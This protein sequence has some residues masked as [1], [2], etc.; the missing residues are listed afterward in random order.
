MDKSIRRLVLD[1]LKPSDK[2]TTIELAQLLCKID[3]VKGVNINLEEID[4]ET[5]TVKITIEGK[6]AY[7]KILELFGNYGVVVHSV[8]QVVAGSEVVE[9]VETPQD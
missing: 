6:L 8:D 1:V 7:D 3:D 5:E 2:P 9:A 4:K